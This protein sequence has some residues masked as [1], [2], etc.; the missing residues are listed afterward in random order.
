[1]DTFGSGLQGDMCRHM[2]KHRLWSGINRLGLAVSG[3]SDSVAL[4][5]LMAP[6]CR[7]LGVECVVLHFNHGLR[8]EAASEEAFVRDLASRA[9]LPVVT[10]YARLA[11][12]RPDG[13]SLEMAAR[14]ARME[15][16]RKQIA[17][18]KLDAIATGHQA[19]DLA[20]MV[21]L[22]LSRGAG[23]SGLSALRPESNLDGMRIIRPLLPFSNSALREW[24]AGQGQN[25]CDDQSNRDLHIQRNL[26][27]HRVLPWLEENFD[28]ALRDHLTQTAT[29]LADD[30]I[31]LEDLA[32]QKL[33]E[34]DIGERMPGS[35]AAIWIGNLRQTPVV[36][37]RRVL[38]QWLFANGYSEATGYDSIR[39]LCERVME[40]R[41]GIVNLPGNL[42][43]EIRGDMLLILTGQEIPLP[44]KLNL[45]GET[46]WGKWRIKASPDHGWRSCPGRVGDRQAVAWLSAKACASVF[47]LTVRSRMPGDYISPTGLRGTRK[48]QD[49]FT[50]AKL[51]IVERD[52][53]PVVVAGSNKA[54]CLPGYRINADFAVESPDAPSIRLDFCYFGED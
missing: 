49:V 54:V 41:N 40:K 44:V 6:V 23:S 26:V 38:R 52:Q 17:E 39:G 36:L 12:E 28:P 2:Y 19:D 35:Q 5:L 8:A 25:W 50:D 20:E 42:S 18:Q 16:F 9:G 3:G 4:L 47:G 51:S 37:M 22:R 33:N 29:L 1:M 13:V 48:L 21:L 45:N 7:K 14:Q 31:F 11:D 10:G 15:F 43:L 30:D 32:A 24:L 46:V 27:R 53:I 34:I